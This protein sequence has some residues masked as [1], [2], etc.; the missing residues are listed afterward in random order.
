MRQF[1]TVS[2]FPKRMTNY[3]LFAELPTLCFGERAVGSTVLR[4]ARSFSWLEKDL[5]NMVSLVKKSLLKQVYCNLLLPNVYI[6]K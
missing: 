6:M 1:D 2:V 5:A 4:L 3:N